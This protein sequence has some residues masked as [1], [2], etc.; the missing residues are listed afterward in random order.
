MTELA[1]HHMRFVAQRLPRDLRDLLRIHAGK[2]FVGGGFIRACVAGEIPNDIDVFGNDPEWLLSVASGLSAQRPG[3]RI[4]QS[5]NAITLITPDRMPVQFITRWTFQDARSLVN[6][7]DFTVC[8]AAVYRNGR[9]DNSKWLSVISPRF[10]QD[11]AGKNIVYTSPERNEDAGGSLLR[12]IKYIQR[13]YHIQVGSLGAVL[14]RIHMSARDVSSGGELDIA[15][16]YTVL[17][18]E[19]DPLLIIDGFEFVDDHEPVEGAPT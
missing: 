6:S 5:S 12:V 4:H 10:Y 16:V 17:L 9:S 13:G 11:L 7:F 14:A 15:E 3:S 18:R 1:K 19:V 8:Q 2:L